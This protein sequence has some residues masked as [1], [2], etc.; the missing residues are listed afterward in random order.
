MAILLLVTCNAPEV[1]LRSPDLS[2]SNK[3]AKT[4]LI[5]IT[6]SN[7]TATLFRSQGQSQIRSLADDD[8]QYPPKTIASKQVVGRLKSM[9]W[10]DY[11]YATVGTK[12]KSVTFLI[13]TL[14]EDCLLR[15]SQRKMLTVRYDEVERYI[16]QAGGYHRVNWIKKI[17]GIDVNKWGKSRSRSQLKQCQ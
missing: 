5:P 1:R 4:S 17:D 10:G 2:V 3:S 15:Q 13:E 12:K 16:P 6:R 8:R 9:F 14:A 11:F 7:A